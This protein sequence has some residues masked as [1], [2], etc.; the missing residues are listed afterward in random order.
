MKG[1]TLIVKTITRWVKAFIFLFGLYIVLFGHLTPGGGFAGG[2][3]IACSFILLTLAFGK[4]TAL[5]RVSRGVASELDS[6]GGLIFLVVALLGISI[7]G[8]F[9]ANFIQTKPE[10]MFKF[11]SA[12]TIPINNIA[13]GIKVSTSLFL[14]FVILS[15]I[16]VVLTGEN[17]RKMFH[18]TREDEAK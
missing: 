3:I 11:L 18:N 10:W 2:V 17:E 9:F 12:G 8:V 1:M 16:R 15:A 13:I 7:G 14:I 4:E 5:K 6:V